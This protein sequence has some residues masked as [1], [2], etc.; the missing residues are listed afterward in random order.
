MKNERTSIEPILLE[1]TQKKQH[2]N[3]TWPTDYKQLVHAHNGTISVDS[4]LER[5][6]IILYFRFFVGKTYV[7]LFFFLESFAKLKFMQII[8]W[9]CIYGIYEGKNIINDLGKGIFFWK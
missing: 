6:T 5:T 3:W 7:R 9:G 2:W 1:Q 8:I 4:A